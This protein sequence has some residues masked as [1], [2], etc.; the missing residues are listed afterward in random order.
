MQLLI[1]L[2]FYSLWHIGDISR[3]LILW[4]GPLV[5]SLPM[6]LRL[7]SFPIFRLAHTWW[8]LFQKRVERTKF[9]IYVVFFFV[10]F[11]ALL[12]Y[13]CVYRRYTCEFDTYQ[14]LVGC[15]FGVLQLSQP[16]RFNNA[17]Y[18]GILL[19]ETF[20]YTKGVFSGCNSKDTRN[21]DQKKNGEKTNKGRRTRTLL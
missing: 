2:R 13:I 8:K 16:I 9:D 20:E 11:F 21:N 15:F 4:L 17:A 19:K 6:I 12:C 5:L 14:W 3:T 10:F 18:L 1:K 7:F